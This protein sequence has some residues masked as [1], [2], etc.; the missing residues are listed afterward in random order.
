MRYPYERFLRYLVSRKANVHRALGRIGLPSVGDL[1][2]PSTLARLCAS[3]PPH[4]M[5]YLRAPRGRPVPKEGF[6]DWA[7]EHEI[8]LLWR[9]QPEFR[10]GE[11][12]PA[13]ALA[14]RLFYSP[15]MRATLGMLL[16]AEVGRDDICQIVKERFGIESVDAALSIYEPVYWDFRQTTG[17]LWQ[18]VLGTFAPEERQ[19]Y[20]HGLRWP[21]PRLEELRQLL[22]LATDDD[23]E[24][25]LKE[26]LAIAKQGLREAVNAPIPE[27]QNVFKW[28]AL[29]ERTAAQVRKGAKAQL[30]Q[31]EAAPDPA[32]AFNLFSV[33]VDKLPIPTLAELQGELP[34]MPGGGGRK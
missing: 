14:G 5:R 16:L 13:L 2:A 30:K 3:A 33:T 34:E 32:A 15:V 29:V 12:S 19:F 27:Y 24:A 31:G 18:D 1:W 4:I 28:A 20:A 7:T 22:G 26:T 25:A 8:G 17:A 21:P 6:L 9:D 10:I 11:P 23:P